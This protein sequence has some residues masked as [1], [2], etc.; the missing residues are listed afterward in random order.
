MQ[1]FHFY[2]DRSDLE[3]VPSGVKNLMRRDNLFNLT[4]L[5]ANCTVD[6]DPGRVC[7]WSVGGGVGS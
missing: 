6:I 2:V 3:V 5:A 4:V 7:R 1:M